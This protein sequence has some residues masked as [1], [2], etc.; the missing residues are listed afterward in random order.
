MSSVTS[1]FRELCHFLYPKVRWG[2]IPKS[3]NFWILKF[4]FYLKFFSKFLNVISNYT[5]QQVLS[6]N[7]GQMW[8]LYWYLWETSEALRFGSQ[9]QTWKKWVLSSSPFL[10]MKEVHKFMY[11]LNHKNVPKIA[12]FSDWPHSFFH[13]WI[14]A[15]NIADLWLLKGPPPHF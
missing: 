7:R 9:I 15:N 1:K 10:R 13:K 14:I 8:L 3:E 6:S 12:I 4:S 5:Y 2:E 11:F